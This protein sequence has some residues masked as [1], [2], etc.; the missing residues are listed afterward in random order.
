MIQMKSLHKIVKEFFHK[1]FSGK[2]HRMLSINQ[3]APLTQRL[4]S[5]STVQL[6]NEFLE[7]EF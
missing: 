5:L 6:R 3:K 2:V 7:F 1:H 4:L